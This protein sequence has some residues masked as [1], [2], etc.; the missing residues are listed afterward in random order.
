MRG[1]IRKLRRAFKPD[2]DDK[3]I[4]SYQSIKFSFFTNTKDKIPPLNKSF[5]VYKF[6]CPGCN[7]AYVG[8]TNRTS[9]ERTNEHAWDDKESAVFYHLF[10]FVPNLIF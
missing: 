1:C 4:V 10:L 5:V 8:K 2:A 7:A 3:F 9:L 6:N